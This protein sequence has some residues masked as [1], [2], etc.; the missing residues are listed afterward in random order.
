MLRTLAIAASIVGAY[1]FVPALVVARST[2]LKMSFEN[3]IST[4]TYMYNDEYVDVCLSVMQ[5]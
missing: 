3:G 5:Y 1:A 4:Y 2:L